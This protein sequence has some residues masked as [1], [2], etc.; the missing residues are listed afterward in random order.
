LHNRIREQLTGIFRDSLRISQMRAP[1]AV[2]AQRATTTTGIQ[3]ERMAHR[4]QKRPS[5]E[6]RRRSI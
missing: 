6:F 5:R 1:S 3:P 2:V 4:L